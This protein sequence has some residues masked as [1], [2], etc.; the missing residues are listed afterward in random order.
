MAVD[1]LNDYF[2]QTVVRL[3]PFTSLVFLVCVSA[4]PFDVA[5]WS[6]VGSMLVYLGVFFWVSYDFN[7]LSYLGVFIVGILL[8]ILNG[9]ILGVNALIFLILVVFFSHKQNTLI[10]KSF[11]VVWFNLV[12]ISCLWVLFIYIIHCLYYLKILDFYPLFLQWFFC[13]FAYPVVAITLGNVRKRLLYKL[14]G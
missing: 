6:D 1:S 13:I 5:F 2:W 8:D 12:F 9:G 10:G 4:L 3:F 14:Y 7:V 11:N